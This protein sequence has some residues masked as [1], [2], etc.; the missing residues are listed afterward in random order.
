MFERVAAIASCRCGSY[1]KK[2]N[3]PPQTAEDETRHYST[4]WLCRYDSERMDESPIRS[5]LVGIFCLGH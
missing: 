1:F 4:K 5:I 2:L 3:I